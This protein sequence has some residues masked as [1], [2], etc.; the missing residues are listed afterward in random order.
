MD[1][2]LALAKIKY[3]FMID[4]LS[5]DTLRDFLELRGYRDYTDFDGG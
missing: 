2:N 3:N 1:E 4:N 5:T